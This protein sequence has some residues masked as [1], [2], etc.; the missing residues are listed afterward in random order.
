MAITEAYRGRN[1][2]SYLEIQV[3]GSGSTTLSEFQAARAVICLQGTLTGPRTIRAPISADDR[4]VWILKN[5]TAGNFPLEFGV[6]NGN[7]YPVS[8]GGAIQVYANGIEVSRVTG[9]TLEIAATLNSTQIKALLTTPVVLVAAPG[10]G[11][12]LHFLSAMLIFEYGG[13]N[14]F[15]ANLGVLQIGWIDGADGYEPASEVIAAAGFL[16]GTANQVVVLRYSQ[17]A[18]IPQSGAENMALA[19]INLVANLTGNAANDNILHLWIRY[20]IYETGF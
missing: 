4:M 19:I 10:S 13:S 16:D 17:P 7:S 5:E 3:P 15:V 6:V 2:D 18:A 8:R 14:V 20:A 11:K 12:I 1:K 9:S